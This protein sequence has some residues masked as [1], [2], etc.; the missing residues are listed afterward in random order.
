MISS[1]KAKK[2]KISKARTKADRIE[3]KKHLGDEPFFS[4]IPTDP[5]ARKWAT[6]KAYNWYSYFFEYEDWPDVVLDHFS[7]TGILTP[8]TEGLVK[9]IDPKILI[10][11][12]IPQL[13][14]MRMI[15]RG[16]PATPQETKKV[17]DLVQNILIVGREQERKSQLKAFASNTSE[18]RST[19]DQ[20]SSLVYDSLMGLEDAW[21]DGLEPNFSLLEECRGRGETKQAIK[22]VLIPWIA[23]RKAGIKD[24]LD[25]PDPQHPRPLLKRRLTLLT[26][27]L[28]EAETLLSESTRK[29]R[30]PKAKS[31]EQQVKQLLFLPED[32][33]TKVKSVAP[34]SLV[35]SQ[36][37]LLYNVKYRTVAL[38]EAVDEKGIQVRRTTLENIKENPLKWK[39]RKPKEILDQILES[40]TKAKVLKI[41][42]SLK[43]K[44][45]EA[46]GRSNQDTVL[47]KCFQ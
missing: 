36:L 28:E 17:E 40:P 32:P 45:Q 37:A 16:W 19:S 18:K 39:L 47:L 20:I 6:I 1:P 7:E 46:N 24:E 44:P 25:Q 11:L 12:G 22:T 30:K 35:K 2:P 14:M 5:E 21:M 8:E 33:D 23:T 42:E 4:D 9:A 34:A 38:Y 26:R 13:K 29:T 15:K 43:T 27:L 31:P 41:L 10:T 3:A